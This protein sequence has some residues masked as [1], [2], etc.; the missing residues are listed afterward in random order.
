MKNSI[1]LSPKHGVNPTIPVC[2]Y[3][4][5]DKGML[6]LAGK[7]DKKDTEM[8][9]RCVIDA[10]PCEKCQKIW[11]NGIALIRA[12]KTESKNSIPVVAQNG[13]NLYIDGS[14]MVIKEETA[15]RMFQMPMVK[16]NPVYLEDQIFDQLLKQWDDLQ[17]AR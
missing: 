9:M 10:V 2:L 6:A 3:C 8:P 1:K 11:S 13:E 16:G 5:K 7:I 4:G 12:S 15:R 17:N 14:S